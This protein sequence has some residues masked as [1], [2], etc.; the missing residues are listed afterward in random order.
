MSI[1]P[2]PVWDINGT[3]LTPPLSGHQGSGYGANEVPTSDE[4]NGVLNGITSYL[5]FLGDHPNLSQLI[6][7]ATPGT[8]GADPE[9]TQENVQTDV[10]YA[11]V[12]HGGSAYLKQ[13][14][15]NAKIKIAPG[16]LYQLTGGNLL[17]WHSDGTSE[18]T[19]ANGD[20]SNPRVDVLEMSIA[21]SALTGATTAT[22]QWKTGT[23][24]ASPAYPTL[25]S[26]FSAIA[27][28]VVGTNYV[29]AAPLVLG[30]D[31]AGAV[32]VVHDQRMP[33]NVRGFHTLPNQFQFDTTN[34]QLDFGSY[35]QKI[36]TNTVS[37]AIPCLG[38]GG[39]G[40]LIAVACGTQNTNVLPTINL[41]RRQ[42]ANSGSSIAITDVN[43]AT[44]NFGGD[45]NVY[46][47]FIYGGASNAVKFQ[48]TDASFA[49][50]PIVLPSAAGMGAPIWTS[51]KRCPNAPFTD[52][53]DGTLS[54]W[55]VAS[56]NLVIK[57]TAAGGSDSGSQWGPATFYV[58]CGLGR[59]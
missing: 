15:T 48:G 41:A 46:Y 17:A 59:S 30:V 44:I 16:I 38:G 42:L 7:M 29:A 12:P 25:D 13:G 31:T 11:L 8:A 1:P 51:G 26:G 47:R 33:F 35:L 20:P 5:A 57:F 34:Y 10:M 19:V 32:A 39:I 49:A 55:R 22:I 6:P 28:V 14:S 18:F 3:H 58:A 27:A 24:A 43:L 21:A 50:G 2:L 56:E 45:I 4:L 23:P 9:L 53:S 37:M 54:P 36:T 52:A 40:R